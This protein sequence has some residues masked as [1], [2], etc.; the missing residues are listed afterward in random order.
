MAD[1]TGTREP[2]YL[3]VST[4]QPARIKLEGLRIKKAVYDERRM[5]ALVPWAVSPTAVDFATT[6]LRYHFPSIKVNILYHPFGSHK[7]RLPGEFLN[8]GFK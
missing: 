8:L 6:R 5:R 1:R 2:A 4:T 3:S 7:H